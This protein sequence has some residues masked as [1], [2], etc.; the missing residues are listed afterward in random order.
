MNKK[1]FTFLEKIKLCNDLGIFLS[2]LD[3]SND[4]NQI[5]KSLVKNLLTKLAQWRKDLQ[6]R[7][8]YYDV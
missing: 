6:L 3:N 4:T 5:D 8:Y 2:G 1:D 7:Q